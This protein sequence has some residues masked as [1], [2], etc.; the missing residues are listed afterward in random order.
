MNKLLILSFWK[1]IN[2]LLDP[3]KGLEQEQD[4]HANNMMRL[5]Q[6]MGRL[7][8]RRTQVHSASEYFIC[9]FIIFIV[10]G[11]MG[12]FQGKTNKVISFMTCGGEFKHLNQCGAHCNLGSGGWALSSPPSSTL[13]T[14]HTFFQRKQWK[15]RTSYFVRETETKPL[16]CLDSILILLIC[17][18][19][20]L[21]K[22]EESAHWPR[23]RHAIWMW[24]APPPAAT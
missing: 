1:Y 10:F 4:Q 22:K 23:G 14:A 5:N 18:V 7:C 2:H 15:S 13:G 11:V 20:C 8:R 19:I 21:W 17:I 3:N 12:F 9:F 6:W 16:R 24:W